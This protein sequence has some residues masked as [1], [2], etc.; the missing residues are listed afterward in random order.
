MVFGAEE[1]A[2]LSPH[3]FRA[4]GGDRAAFALRQ[5]RL[6]GMNATAA[7]PAEL[8]YQNDRAFLGHPRGLGYLAFAEGWERFSYYGMTALLAL[9][10]AQHLFQPG[11]IERI[12]GFGP[13]RALLEGMFGPL[14]PL[15]LGGAV[16]GLYGG[17]V[18][19]TPLLGG[20]VADRF[21]GRTRAVVFGASSMA[22]GHFCM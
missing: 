8:D 3:A 15:T 14:T 19:L 22:I 18:Y 9:Y 1:P 13:F 20:F 10:G 16:A 5:G 11:H 4:D 7:A 17:F 21:I 2:L 12:W 6:L